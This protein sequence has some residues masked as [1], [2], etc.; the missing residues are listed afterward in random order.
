MTDVTGTAYSTGTAYPQ[1]RQSSA[2]WKIVD[3]TLLVL[4]IIAS[5]E[6]LVQTGVQS[7]VWLLCYA[8]ALLRIGMNWAVIYPVM[9]RNWPL[10]VYA[11]VALVSVLWSLKPS[12]SLVASIQLNMTVLIAFYLGWRYSMHM[13][14]RTMALIFLIAILLSLLHWATGMFPWPVYTRA[15][16]LAGLFSHKNMLGGRAMFLSVFILAFLFMGPGGGLLRSKAFLLPSLGIALLALVMSQAITALLTLFLVTGVLAL[17]CLSRLPRSITVIFVSVIL[18]TLS[19]TPLLLVVFS[20]DPVDTVLG[21]VGKDATLTG[22]TLLWEVARE[23]AAE[24]PILGVGYAAFW[25]APRFANEV[26]MTQYAGAVTSTSFHNFAL[27]ILVASGPLG[28]LS[29]LALIG[30]VIRRLWRTYTGTTLLVQRIIAAAFLTLSLAAILDG[31]TATGL[32]RQHEF[33]LIFLVAV[34]VSAGEDW[35]QERRQAAAPNCA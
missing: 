3:A 30:T 23:V 27:E 9:L 11:L 19:V 5:A 16:G 21:L 7:V 1:M 33:Y 35:R 24:Y 28:L 31:A 17:L 29:M 32:Y 4:A 18:L 22:R 20:I 10:F 8:L 26:L 15:G 12:V 6:M 34:A 14:L 25:S 2:V 13:L